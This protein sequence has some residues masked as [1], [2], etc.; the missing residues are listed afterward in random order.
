[1]NGSPGRG[2]NKDLTNEREIGHVTRWLFV[3]SRVSDELNSGP[4]FLQRPWWVP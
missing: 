2:R 1:M 3:V 4:L